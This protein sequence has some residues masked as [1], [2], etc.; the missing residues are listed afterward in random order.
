M[1]V[2]YCSE[3]DIYIYIYIYI[4]DVQRYRGLNSHVPDNMDSQYAHQR[5]SIVRLHTSGSKAMLGPA[6]GRTQSFIE[7]QSMFIFCISK[8]LLKIYFF[9]VTSN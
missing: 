4:C 3:E 2:L 8:M 9:S 7:E 5:K 6:L 1:V